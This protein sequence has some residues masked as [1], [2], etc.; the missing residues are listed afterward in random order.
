[1]DHD[2]DLCG[3]EDL[4]DLGQDGPGLFG[5]EP[6]VATGR[7]ST[8]AAKTKRGSAPA[9]A[10]GLT[11]P[12]APLALYRRYRPDTFEEIIGQ[13]HV[14]VP[15]QRA[16]VNGK[17][18]HAYLF[19]GPRGCGKTT[20][21]RIL[22][23]ALNCEK[24]PLPIPCGTCQSCLDLARGGSGS[25][26]VR[27]IDAASHGLV[28]D[29]RELRER[30]YYTPVQSRFKIYIIDEAHMVT[31][32]GFNALL[33]VVEEPPE[34]VKFIFATTAPEKVLATIRSRT[35]HYP[36][37]LVPPKV[38]GEY[39]ASVCTQEGINVEPAALGLVVRAGAG[40]VRDSLS[41]LDQL[42]GS[43]ADNLVSYT[44]AAALLGYTS[45]TLLDEII[46]AFAIADSQGVFVAIE[47][48]IEAGID[49][50]RF[51][52]DLLN[53]LRDLIIVSAVPTA[54]NDH[55]V[56]VAQDQ[57]D[58]LTTQAKAMGPGELTRAAEVIAAGL[59]EMRG[60]TAPRLY[61][62]LMCSRVLLPG[63]DVDG[64]G[65]HARLDRLERRFNIADQAAAEETVLLPISQSAVGESVAA[66][67]QIPA[68][69]SEKST[70]TL[71]PDAP[72]TL[73][74]TAPASHEPKPAV[75]ALPQPIPEPVATKQPAT[76]VVAL[77]SETVKSPATS[78]TLGT[79]D[80]RGLWP[81]ILDE[82][83][84]LRRFTW[85]LLS[86]NAQISEVKGDILVLAMANPGAKDSFARGGSVDVLKQAIMTAIGANLQIEVVLDARAEQPV[87]TQ[88][89]PEVQRSEPKTPGAA[90]RARKNI[91][92]TRT[93]GAPDE[94]EI[95]PS[96]D[97]ETLDDAKDVAELLRN[98]LGATL[99]ETT[100]E[101]G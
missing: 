52:E 45:D 67:K 48:V 64:R 100:M 101:K 12:P 58:R 50:H 35:H 54:L 60:T 71:E 1:M 30:V 31:T 39:L 28:E 99:L 87:A 9:G 40:S 91:K 98:E 44:Q 3:A 23:R 89:M 93:P 70:T 34:H 13:E 65:I 26:D 66:A 74:Q 16:L 49:P 61:L 4:L 85:I 90:D 84:Q 88:T 36:F 57:G 73:A 18:N 10:E 68:T 79:T 8:S 22:A 96:R 25:I 72:T 14:T 75:S 29:A 69:D 86:Q 92:P 38:L 63:A 41:V 77:P 37:R 7:K 33:K 94:P 62:E 32:Q 5:I 51:A 81:K 47:K 24:G 46:D 80:L 83:K 53:R 20:S 76:D 43:A 21:A 27:E 6:K 56:D 19:S 55:L 78:S 97:D 17:V 95:E 42:L 82:V 15:L 2:E 11:R 59:T